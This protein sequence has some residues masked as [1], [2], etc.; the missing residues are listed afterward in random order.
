MGFNEAIG[1]SRVWLFLQSVLCSCSNSVCVCVCVVCVCFV[2]CRK[3]RI[4][5]V[6]AL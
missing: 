3:K 4:I 1:L 2:L 5:N 6:L